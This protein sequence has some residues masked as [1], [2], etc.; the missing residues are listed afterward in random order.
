MG[1][2]PPPP[3]STVFS[4]IVS[5]F[6]SSGSMLW[7]QPLDPGA[8]PTALVANANGVYVSGRAQLLPGKSFLRSFDSSGNLQWTREFP[9]DTANRL[10]VDTTTVYMAG[11]TS[12]TLPGQ[13]SA[14]AGDVYVRSYNLNGDELWTHQ[15]GSYQD[16]LA[17][18]IAVNAGGIYVSGTVASGLY[19]TVTSSVFLAKLTSDPSPASSSPRIHQECVLNSANLLGGGVA[20]GEIV[21]ILGSTIGPVDPVAYT[22]GQDGRIPTTLAETRALFNGVA[23]PLLSVSAE[24]IMAI[25]PSSVADGSSVDVQVEYKGVRSQVVNLPALTSRPGVFSLNRAGTGQAAAL[26]EDGT[27]N[28][29]SNPAARG[30]IVTF[31]V[32][33]AGRNKTLSPDDQI[34]SDPPP[35]PKDT[36]HVAMTYPPY[37][38]LEDAAFPDVLYAGGVPGS[39]EGLVQVNV[40]LPAQGQYAPPA[41]LWSPQVFVDSLDSPPWYARSIVSQNLVTI[42]VR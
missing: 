3:G 38:D 20:P 2:I 7:T 17:N 34:Q 14:G 35:T 27:I 11:S 32:T 21:T 26:N 4:G 42:S 10:A 31:Y 30:S 29:P 8:F 25:V 39:V 9:I 15:F 13:C 12:D 37:F 6:D 33:G 18:Q 40:R 24:Q 16:D 28:S 22:V 19:V 1:A 41:G 5:K 23:A 36:V